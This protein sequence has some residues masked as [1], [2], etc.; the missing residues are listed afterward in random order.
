MRCPAL[1]RLFAS[2]LI[3]HKWLVFGRNALTSVLGE[4]YRPIYPVLED[5]K[6]RNAAERVQHPGLRRVV[7]RE[8]Y[9]QKG[10]DSQEAEKPAGCLVAGEAL[11]FQEGSCMVVFW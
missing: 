9:G 8:M 1:G 4:P 2:L 3:R 7:G 10:I 5:D 11:I 6:K